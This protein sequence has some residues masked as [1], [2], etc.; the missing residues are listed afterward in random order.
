MTD[1]RLFETGGDCRRTIF[2]FIS[3]T[4]RTVGHLSIS[5]TRLL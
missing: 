2:H 4:H 3:R 1:G 5:K